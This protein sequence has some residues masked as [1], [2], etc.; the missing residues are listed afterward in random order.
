V[1]QTNE[2]VVE[3]LI[4]NLLSIGQVQ[5]VLQNLLRE[6]VSI[7]DMPSILEVLADH[8]PIT[9]DTDLLTEFARQKLARSIIRNYVTATGELPLMTIGADIEDALSRSI[10]ETERGAY[11]TLDPD[12]GQRILT[13]ISNAIT[14]LTR[15]NLQPVVLST[16]MI[17]RHL[18]KLTE[19]FISNLVVLSH[20][21][22]TATTRL[23]IMGE[24]TFSY[25][26]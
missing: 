10:N 21:E 8:A 7:R 14:Q 16:P 19:R 3:E 4:P 12:T 22:L 5:K 20:S 18:R 25:A 2:K 9:H 26:D 6:R 1:A 17:R 13:A 15:Q 23:K 24:V 11:L